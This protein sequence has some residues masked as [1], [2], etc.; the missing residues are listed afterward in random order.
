MRQECLY[1]GKALYLSSSLYWH[2]VELGGELTSRSQTDTMYI[3]VR[4]A[5]VDSFD[6]RPL[7]LIVATVDTVDKLIAKFWGFSLLFSSN[8]FCTPE[9][10]QSN[11]LIVGSGSFGYRA[12]RFPCDEDGV[13]GRLLHVRPWRSKS[14]LSRWQTAAQA[15]VVSWLLLA[16]WAAIRRALSVLSGTVGW[17]LVGALQASPQGAMFRDNALNDKTHSNTRWS[18]EYV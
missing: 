17:T 14:Y 12:P 16:S 6:C 15:Q 8:A 10:V 13:L 11:M 1:R 5:I 2:G 4:G 3:T 18:A 9:T 7:Q